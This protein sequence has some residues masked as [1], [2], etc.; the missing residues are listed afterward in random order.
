M[1]LYRVLQPRP[2]RRCVR[3]SPS[4]KNYTAEFRQ[5]TADYVISTGHSVKQMARELD[6][7]DKTLSNWVAKRKRELSGAAAEDKA[8]RERKM[9]NEFLKKAAAFFAKSQA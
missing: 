3:D 8:L 7:N 1:F 9:E 4:P 5:Q 6:I 2:R